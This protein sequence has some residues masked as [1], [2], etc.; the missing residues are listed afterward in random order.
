MPDRTRIRA[1]AT[2]MV[3]QTPPHMTVVVAG[4]PMPDTHRQDARGVD[5]GALDV[6]QASVTHV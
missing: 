1:S 4:E 5:L 3:W 2:A 6:V